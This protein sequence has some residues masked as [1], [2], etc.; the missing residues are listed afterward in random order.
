MSTTAGR[1]F[2][3]LTRAAFSRGKSVHNATPTVG[4][5]K[6]VQSLALSSQK[7]TE[8]KDGD[9]DVNN[10]PIKFSTSLASHR[11]WKVERAMGSNFTRPWRKVL[12]FMV[13]FSSIIL[14]CALRS[15]TDI[16]VKLDK[17]LL[18]YLP[19]LLPDEEE[20]EDQD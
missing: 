8:S 12:P 16:D 18:E 13:V 17:H 3:S 10:G 6:S 1:L 4:R 15:E 9:T 11:T 14:W 2:S 7:S 5:F 19:N 20:G